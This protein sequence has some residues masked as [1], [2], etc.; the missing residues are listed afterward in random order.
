ML[1]RQ[2]KALSAVGISH[3]FPHRVSKRDPLAGV[4]PVCAH[5][6]KRPLPADDD[7]WGYPAEEGQNR[8]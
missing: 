3:V 6:A 4:A 7:T 8:E 5:V 2:S 1:D